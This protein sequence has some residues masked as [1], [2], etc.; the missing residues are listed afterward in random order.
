MK[1]IIIRMAKNGCPIKKNSIITN[2]HTMHVYIRNP[3]AKLSI[4][5]IFQPLIV[6]IM[7]STIKYCDSIIHCCEN[8]LYICIVYSVFNCG[9][10]P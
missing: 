7:K 10:G 3:L 1:A 6:V 9:S 8:N 2:I 5:P 4:K